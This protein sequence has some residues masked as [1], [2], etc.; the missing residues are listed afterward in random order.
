MLSVVL[1]LGIMGHH[2]DENNQPEERNNNWFDHDCL[3]CCRRPSGLAA[4]SET[5]KM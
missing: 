3:P 2:K 4:S 1:S 5:I